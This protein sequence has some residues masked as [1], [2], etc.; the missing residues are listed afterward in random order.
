MVLLLPQFSVRTVATK[1]T[2]CNDHPDC[3]FTVKKYYVQRH[4]KQPPCSPQ[5]PLSNPASLHPA[6]HGEPSSAH[7]GDSAS[8]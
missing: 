5:A 2:C 7:K 4:L 6:A 8:T 3:S 1:A